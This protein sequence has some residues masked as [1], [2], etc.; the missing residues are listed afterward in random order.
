MKTGKW[1]ILIAVIVAAF[2]LLRGCGDSTPKTFENV[3]VVDTV[4][5]V[6]Q[7]TIV[8]SIEDRIDRA[9][10]KTETKVEVMAEEM[11]TLK[12][13]VIEYEQGLKQIVYDTVEVQVEPDSVI[14]YNVFEHAKTYGGETY[15]HRDTIQSR[16]V[17][18]EYVQK[19]I[20]K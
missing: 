3:I 16:K 8:I 12:A 4:K 14:I 5:T 6:V 7:D 1:Y 20:I 10:T 15:I 13:E 17:S 11:V 9:V 2:L 18:R 19:Y